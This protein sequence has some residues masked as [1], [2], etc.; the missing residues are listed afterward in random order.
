[1][2]KAAYCDVEYAD[3]YFE[4][5][6][7]ADAW[8]AADEATKAKYLYTASA[9]IADYCYFEDAEGEMFVYDDAT[10]SEAWLQDAACE[11]A[12]YLLSLGKDPTAADKKTTLGVKSTDGTVFDK[13]FAADILCVR[14][15][16]I[17]ENHG[18][19]ISPSATAGNTGVGNISIYK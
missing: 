18:G 8:T 11:Q 9:M 6:A 16:Q 14:C 17:L 7:F 15:R 4:L 19:V 3:I 5:R 13:S 2:I 1:M 10:G 12:L